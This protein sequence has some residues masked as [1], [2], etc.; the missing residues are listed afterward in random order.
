MSF[1]LNHADVQAIHSVRLSLLM[2]QLTAASVL[3]VNTDIGQWFDSAPKV[4]T[5]DLSLFL[6]VLHALSKYCLY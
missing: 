6:E 4:A 3:A 1:L 2:E 5:L